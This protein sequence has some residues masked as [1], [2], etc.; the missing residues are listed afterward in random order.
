[1]RLPKDKF[2]LEAVSELKAAGYPVYAPLLDGL[3]D[4]VADGNWPVATPVADLLVSAGAGALPVLQRVLQGNDSNHQCFVLEL[5]VGRLSP[6][7]V[8]ALRVILEKL[9][10]SPNQDQ[11]G[12]G[13]PDLAIDILQALD[14][15]R[16]ATP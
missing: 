4:W 12:E 6:D 1:M 8:A 7:V 2:D 10:T 15:E 16:S 9:S 13:V 14:G 3:A 11:I 5:V